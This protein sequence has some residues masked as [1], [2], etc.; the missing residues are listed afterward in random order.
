M[1]RRLKGN[2]PGHP[3]WSKLHP[4]YALLGINEIK[5]AYFV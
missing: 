1:K 5:T 3:L 2:A 4:P